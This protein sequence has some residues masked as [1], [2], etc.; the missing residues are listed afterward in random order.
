MVAVQERKETMSL[1]IQRGQE[2][3]VKRKN[4]A[5]ILFEISTLLKAAR[6]I[7]DHR[8]VPRHVLSDAARVGK[9]KCHEDRRYTRDYCTKAIIRR[10]RGTRAGRPASCGLPRLRRPSPGNSRQT[11]LYAVP[12]HH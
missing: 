2:V 6:F 11:H 7:E 12:Q 3:V 1:A 9:A 4:D 10:C 5:G 8:H